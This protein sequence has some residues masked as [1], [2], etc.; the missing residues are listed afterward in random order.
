[1]SE[2]IYQAMVAESDKIGIFGHGF[3]YSGHPVAASVAL[4]ALA[5]YEERDIAGYVR[6]VSPVLQDG[7]RR[8]CDHPMIGEVRG[9]GLVAAVEL[10]RDKQTK[11]SFAPAS[12]VG[13]YL[14]K[15][16]EAH[17]LIL[18]AMP[19][20]VI[21]FSPPLIISAADIEELIERFQ[22]ALDDT[23]AWAKRERLI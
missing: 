16:A 8:L 6:E 17:G 14:A 19:G 20:D 13:A 12:G 22:R 3:T 9:I 11:D 21:A 7:L 18:R 1:M 23:H 2:P 15:R 10:V 4:E 5:I